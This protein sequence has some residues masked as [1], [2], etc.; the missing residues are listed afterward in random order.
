M[1]SF[2]SRTL[3]CSTLLVVAGACSSGSGGTRTNAPAPEASKAGQSVSARDVR[4][5][6]T[7]SVE[8]TLEGRFPGV[9][10]L[11][12]SSGGLSIRIRG[13]ASFTGPNAPLYVIDGSPVE[14][15]PDGDLIGLNPSDIESIKV[16]KDAASTAFYGVRGGNGVVVIK[17]KRPGR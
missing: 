5:T 2:P 15:G 16:L 12:T 1:S 17:T 4:D 6:P 11:R 13:A 10:V 14:P 7:E 8:K 3:L 9:T